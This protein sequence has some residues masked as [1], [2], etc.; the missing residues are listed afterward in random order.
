M[1]TPA[2]DNLIHV[3]K[4]TQNTNLSADYFL[5]TQNKDIKRYRLC[6]IV[7][8]CTEMKRFSKI[9]SFCHKNL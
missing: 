1:P 5:K 3:I 4:V 6:D 7:N 2:Y 8:I 9:F